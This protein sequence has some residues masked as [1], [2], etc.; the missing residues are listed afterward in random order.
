[1]GR[2]RAKIKIKLDLNTFNFFDLYFNNKNQVFPFV[3]KKV[4]SFRL[5]SYSFHSASANEFWS[6]IINEIKYLGFYG[7]VNLILI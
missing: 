1:M 3:L 5:V 7:L 6:Q 4:K 2:N